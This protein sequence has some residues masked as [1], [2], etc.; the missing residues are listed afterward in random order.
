MT[1]LVLA[2]IRGYQI[3]LSP[4]FG[5]HC[6]FYPTCSEY[7]RQAVERHGLVKG[8]RLAAMRVSKCHPWHAGGADPVP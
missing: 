5:N 1:K 3:T 6:R 8:L 4:W 7:A 2:V